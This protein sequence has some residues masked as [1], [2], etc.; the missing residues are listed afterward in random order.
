[1][2]DWTQYINTPASLP[3]RWDNSEVCFTLLSAKI[4]KGFE[5]G[6]R[7]DWMFFPWNL[8]CGLATLRALSVF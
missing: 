1:M 2:A 8:K 6:K 3:F 5:T 7:E 4:M